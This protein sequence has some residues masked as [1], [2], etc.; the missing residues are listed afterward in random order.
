MHTLRSAALLAVA[1]TAFQIQPAALAAQDGAGSTGA[2]VLQLLAGSRAAALSGA[3]TA[4]VGDADVLFYNPAGIGTLRAGASFSYQRHVADIGVASG[5]GVYSL[6]RVVFGAGAVFLDYGDIDE[7][8]PDPAFGGQTGLPTGNTVSASEVAGRLTAA[9]PFMDDR[10]RLGAAVGL[11]SVSLAGISRSTPLFD[12]GA[13]YSFPMI[14]FGASLRNAGGALSGEQLAD[15]DLPTEARL[16]AA[17]SL[18]DPSGFGG[19][20]AADF[21]AELNEGGS[22]LVAGVEA[23]LMPG[24][25]NSIGAVGRFGYNGTAGEEGLGALQIGAGISLGNFAVDYAYQNYDRFGS[26]HRF[27]VRWTRLP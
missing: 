11:V 20:I 26:L 5:A 15:A 7:L 17:L 9:L 2:T 4:A 18:A 21:I 23:G 8:E 14:T 24:G 6:G 16:G 1:T 25:V 22:G 12:V 10:L 13:Q 27:G 19:T 3:Y